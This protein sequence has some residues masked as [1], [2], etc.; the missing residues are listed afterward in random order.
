MNCFEFRRLVLAHPRE[1]TAAQEEHLAQCSRCAKLADDVVAFEAQLEEAVLVS[2]PD[3]LADKI[4]LRQKMRPPARYGLW[5]MAATLVIGVSLGVQLYRT[6]DAAHENLNTAMAVGTNHPAVAAISF[7]IDHEPQLLRENQSGDPDVMMNAFQ[8]VG[9]KLPGEGVS[10][11]YLGK[12]PVPDGTGDHVVLTTPYG[13]V[14]LIL[15]PDY[16][17]GSR[18]MVADRNM[19][20]LASPSGKGGYIVVAPSPQTI[21][22]IERMLAS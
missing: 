10:V 1:K 6:Y 16:P 17:V 2:V 14:T 15:V 7:V 5:A 22:Q 9:L 21:L 12:C 20:A 3:A 18:V 4:L 19:T 8:R 13:H 11:R